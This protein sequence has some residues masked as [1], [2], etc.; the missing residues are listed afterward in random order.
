MVQNNAQTLSSYSEVQCSTCNLSCDS[1]HCCQC[2]SLKSLEIWSIVGLSNTGYQGYESYVKVLLSILPSFFFLKGGW[3][4]MDSFFSSHC[5][6][7]KKGHGA[8]VYLLPCMHMVDGR[9]EFSCIDPTAVL[10]TS[11]FEELTTE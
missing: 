11:L 7:I 6:Q 4:Q 9:I 3:Q 5:I 8:G 2:N 10:H 1:F